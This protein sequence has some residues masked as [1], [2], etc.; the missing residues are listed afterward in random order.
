MALKGDRYLGD[1]DVSFFM[2]QEAERGGALVMLTAGSGAALDQSEA[3]VQYAADPSGEYG[4]GILLGDVVDEDL[5]RTH[6]NFHKDEA[7][8]GSK[9]TILK[10]GWVH[11]NMIVPGVSP[12]G[13]DIAYI[14]ASGYI[15]NVLTTDAPVLGRFESSKDADGYAKVRVNLP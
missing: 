14:G 8:K 12:S 7:Q 6:L 9:V 4:L 1:T 13:G 2:D 5:T 3:A 10:S 11:T 15:T